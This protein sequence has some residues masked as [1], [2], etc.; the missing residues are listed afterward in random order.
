MIERQ[1]RTG[2]HQAGSEIVRDRAT[3]E[4]LIAGDGRIGNG[5]GAL[6]AQCAA[7]PRRAVAEQRHPN[8]R[9]LRSRIGRDRTA[10]DRGVLVHAAIGHGDDSSRRDADCSPLEA[11]LIPRQLTANDGPRRVRGKANR[12]AA[13]IRSAGRR[14]AVDERIFDMQRPVIDDGSAEPIGSRR[15]VARQRD[16]IQREI[17]VIG[18]RPAELRLPIGDLQAGDRDLHIAQQFDAAIQ[19]IRVDDGALI[20]RPDEREVREDVEITRHGPVFARPCNREPISPGRQHDDFRTDPR[21][22]LHDGRPQR[23][24]TLS[25]RCDTVGRVGIHRI[26]RRVDEVCRHGADLERSDVGSRD[27]VPI[28]IQHARHAPLIAQLRRR[29]NRSRVNRRA[30]R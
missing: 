21:V 17:R 27:R 2:Q 23:S 7:A 1:R 6:Q 8:Q 12:P 3:V 20:P 5:R 25:I 9:E 24:P 11:R 14:V 28:S 30:A 22:G 15:R 16:L 10:I 18:D 26:D 13:A 29:R 4:R 19:L